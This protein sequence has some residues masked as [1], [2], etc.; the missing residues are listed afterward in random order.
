[1]KNVVTAATLFALYQATL[2]LGI[3]LLPLALFARRL[4]VRVPVGR[5]VDRLGEAY[6]AHQ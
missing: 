1:M 6:E 5:V 4:G 2:V 3:V